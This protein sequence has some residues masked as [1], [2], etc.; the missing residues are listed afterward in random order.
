MDDTRRSA[1]RRRSPVA[2]AR[3]LRGAGV[4]DAG[5]APWCRSPRR[6]ARR[7]RATATTSY[8]AGRATLVRRPED[9]EPYDRAFAA[10]FEHRADR[11]RRRR[12]RR[13]VGDHAR[14]STTTTGR[15]TGRRRAAS[16]TTTSID[17]ALQRRRGA[18][19][20]RLRRL[21][22][23]RAGRGPPVDGAAAARRAR[24]GARCGWRPTRRPTRR[25]DLRRTVRAALRTGGEPMQRHF[26]EPATALPPPRAAARLSAARWSRTPGRCCASCRPRSPAAGG[27]RRSPSAPGSPGIT[28]ELGAH[29]PDVALAPGD[30]TRVADWSGGTRLGEGLRRFNDE[31]GVRGMA[32]GAIVVI[33]SRRVGPRRP[34]R[35]SPSRCSACSASPTASIWVN[36]LKVTPGYA[37]LAR[38]MAAALPVR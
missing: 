30:A 3:V 31:W 9:I 7:P 34:G 21:H 12:R 16:P 27:S 10:F 11:G 8:W 20:P 17:A 25:A 2:F 35:C 36:P 37:P 19:P 5:R 4:L 29:D 24:R 6:S 26:R 28:R 23:R 15:T 32:R 18:A 14:R 13:A 38:G 33:L 22:R 1:R